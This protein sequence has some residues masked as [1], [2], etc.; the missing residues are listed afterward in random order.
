MWD[1]Q[2]IDKVKSANDIV[3]VIRDYLTLRPS[4][5]NFKALSPF[6]NEKTPSFVVTPSKQI[7]YCFST[8]QGGDVLKFLM[9]TQS[10][11]FP[12]AV[13]MLARR[14][15]IVLPEP[16]AA[17]GGQGAGDSKEA[18]LRL[19]EKTA[20][21]WHELL[22]HDPRAAHAR[23]YV[24]KR[25]LTEETLKAFHIGYAP[26]SWDAHLTWSQQQGF[27]AE[28]SEKAGLSVPKQ[29]GGH[30][31]RFRDRLMFPIFSEAGTVVAF[32]GR[33]LKADTKEA[34]Y[35]NSPETPVFTK[36]RVLFGLYH[37]RK[38]L[39]AAKSAVVCEGQVDLITCHQHGVKTMVAS[40]GTAFTPDHARILKRLVDEV[41]LCFDSDEAGLRAA[42]RSYP[43]L[44]AAGLA[45]RVLS[46]PDGEGGAKQDPDSFVRKSGGEAFLKLVAVAP[47]FWKCQAER[48][49]VL[50]DCSTA[51][52][53]MAYKR[54]YFE[55][56]A[57]CHDATQVEVALMMACARLGVAVDSLK[58]DFRAFRRQAQRRTPAHPGAESGY[59][60]AQP[61]QKK[62]CD[63][64]PV[65]GLL[66]RLC[67]DHLE[68]VPEV[69]RFLPESHVSGM[70]GGT[71]LTQLFQAHSHDSLES[72]Q[73]FLEHLDEIDQDAVLR[74]FAKNSLPVTPD[75]TAAAQEPEAAMKSA[76]LCVSRLEA[77]HLEKE[78]R[79][80]EAS[81]ATMKTPDAMQ[82]LGELSK[83]RQKLDKA[84]NIL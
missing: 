9:L 18:I 7:W 6:K 5:A 63:I 23:D 36:G 30:Y 78:V 37:N 21:W 80:I 77:M 64:H 31:D 60:E 67:L 50:H 59:V 41:V 16:D 82:A 57:E 33:A 75:P 52:G 15:G 39:V 61:P 27:S 43:A 44:A 25:G 65:V 38:E 79:K 73:S 26:D 19:N 62:S 53:S 20:F 81:I 8:S 17:T 10:V 76:L 35:V 51:R 68:I 2:T 42:A 84:R 54:A 58:E 13:R 45:V 83:M 71:I 11:D 56:L 47:D 22:L 70:S 28:L 3:E 24:A 48:L 12:T 1:P 69:Q 46:L 34:K 72:Q 55:L 66:L 14:A 40:Q 74:L 29:N 4:G 49:A 32:S